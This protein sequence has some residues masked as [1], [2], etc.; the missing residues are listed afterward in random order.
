MLDDFYGKVAV[1]TGAGSGFGREFAR[2]GHQLGMRLVL[3]DIQQDALDATAAELRAAGATLIAERVD[4]SVGS[5]VE[6]LAR[7]AR[8]AFGDVDLLFNNAGVGAGGLIWETSERD[9]QWVLGVNLWGVIH[10]IRAFV[11]SMIAKGSAGPRGQHRLGGGPAVGAADGRLQ[12]QQA[13]GGHADRDALPRPQAGEGADRLFGAVSR[14]S[15]PPAST[16]PSATGPADRRTTTP[17]ASQIAARESIRKAVTSGRLTPQDVAKMTFDAIRND[18][19]YIVTHPKILGS[20]ALRHQDIAEMRN[21]SDPYSY[22]PEVAKQAWLTR[23]SRRSSTPPAARARRA[24]RRSGPRPH[25]RSTS[26]RPRSSTWR[27][28][29]W[30]W[31]TTGRWRRAPARRG[32][33][34]RRYCPDAAELGGAAAGAAVLPRRRLR[35]RLDRNA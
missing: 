32:V 11:P 14:H 16:S 13:R 35:H 15:C 1:I 2:L 8:S 24:T 23:T 30:R 9:W 26:A 27:R 34:V 10:G 19:F 17:T 31:S 22:K 3:A 5:D 21:P 4:V 33:R 6:C 20:I 18:R 25:A 28:S 12:R 29:L 7:R